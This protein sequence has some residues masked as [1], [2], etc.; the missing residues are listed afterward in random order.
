MTFALLVILLGAALLI[1]M[2]HFQRRLSRAI[3]DR[4]ERPH[5]L[6]HYPSVT[7]V[8]PV[9]GADPGCEENFRSALDTGYPGDVETLFVFDDESDPGY[10]IACRVVA[11][12]GGPGT[13]RV[14]VAGE[15]PGGPLRMTGKL[16]AMAVGAREA[17]GQRIAFGDSDT[18]PD[19]EVLRALV[20]A[21]EISPDAGCT[22]A[23]VVVS[24]PATAPGDVGYKLLLNAWYGPSV[25]LQAGRSRRVPFIMGQLMVWRREVLEAIGGVECARGQLVDDMYLGTRVQKAGFTNLMIRHPLHIH[26][27]GMS[28]AGFVRLYKRWLCFSRNGLPISFTAPMWIRG[29]EFWLAILLLLGALATGHRW[30]ALVPLTALGA[31]ALGFRALDERLGGVPIPFRWLWVALAVPLLAPFELVSMALVKS[32]DW[33]GRAYALD[34]QARLA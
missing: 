28:F 13:A 29:V 30:A 31:F 26:N 15:P 3:T 1:E 34:A 6:S 16:N 17:R 22:F 32:I 18:R 11:M 33:R 7:V 20:E 21:L 23:P 25:A 27:Q 24:S 8:R 14:I 4:A 10:P 12:H 2:A 5:R 9:R 19:R